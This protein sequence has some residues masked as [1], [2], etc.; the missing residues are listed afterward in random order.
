[1][2][3]ETLKKA[4]NGLYEELTKSDNQ[5][6]DKTILAKAVQLGI[7]YEKERL[8]EDILKLFDSKK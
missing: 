6:S 1:M 4:M 7:Q 5:K 8:K 2:I 3:E